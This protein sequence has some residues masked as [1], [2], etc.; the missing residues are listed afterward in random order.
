[1]LGNNKNVWVSDL[2]ATYSIYK[3]MLMYSCYVMFSCFVVVTYW[4][5]VMYIFGIAVDKEPKTNAN[6]PNALELFDPLTFV[7]I[8]L[9]SRQMISTGLFLVYGSFVDQVKFHVFCLTLTTLPFSFCDSRPAIGRP[10]NNISYL[11]LQRN[12]TVILYT[13]WKQIQSVCKVII[14][15]TFTLIW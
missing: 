14:I 1:M 9:R 6:W 4:L 15:I 2:K 11:D 13:L 3:P 10:Y 12:F 5:F 7:I 8:I